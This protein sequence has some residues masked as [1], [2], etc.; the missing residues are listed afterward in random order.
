MLAQ[1][2]HHPYEDQRKEGSRQRDS[3][4][5]DRRHAL[6]ALMMGRIQ[7]VQGRGGCCDKRSVSHHERPGGRELTEAGETF[8]FCFKQNG[9]QLEFETGEP[10]NLIYVL[11]REYKLLWEE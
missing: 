1:R 11:K 6:G 3:T 8:G 9:K 10:H 4:V 2:R 5:K 7:D